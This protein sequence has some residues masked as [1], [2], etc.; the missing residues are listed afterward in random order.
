MPLL[1]AAGQKKV[2]THLFIP[3]LMK[4]PERHHTD[5]QS[6]RVVNVAVA[7]SICGGV[8]VKE[9]TGTSYQ[10]C[11][12]IQ[13]FNTAKGVAAKS[14][15]GEEYML[16]LKDALQHFSAQ[17]AFRAQRRHALLVHDRSRVHQ[18]KCVQQGLAAMKLESIL[19]P[20]RSPDLM[21]LDYGL[22]GTIK[23]QLGRELPPTA[24]WEAKAPRFMQLLTEASIQAAV[25]GY[26][27]RLEAC[28]AAG[29]YHIDEALKALKRGRSA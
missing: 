16:F 12:E 20:P 13:Q 18:S 19:A 29:G 10:G 25:E 11:E 4:P 17:P 1:G 8:Y 5:K 27:M 9:V 23:Q 7:I 15:G 6:R 21:P 28:I 14:M 24:K 2:P 26:R 3:G 22:F